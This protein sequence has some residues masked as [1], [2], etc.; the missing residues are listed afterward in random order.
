M[1]TRWGLLSLLV[2]GR[3]L[4][5]LLL[6]LLLWLVL[7]LW[8][9]AVLLMLGWHSRA[10][11]THWWLQRRARWRVLAIHPAAIRT[12]TAERLL[13]VLLRGRMEVLLL[14]GRRWAK[15]ILLLRIRS[16]RAGMRV[17]HSS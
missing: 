17:L 6:S 12:R 11:W 14:L 3:A 10:A 8:L 15:R 1:R 9:L 2:G 16:T 7:L 5:R 13:R 4:W